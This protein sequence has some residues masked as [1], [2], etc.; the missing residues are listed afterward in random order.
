MSN[1]IGTSWSE[2]PPHHHVWLCH[3]NR[4]GSCGVSDSISAWLRSAN[5]RH[6]FPPAIIQHATRRY[7]RF[8]RATAISR[9]CW[10]NE[11]WTSPTKQCGAGC[12]SSALPLRDGC[13]GVARGRGGERVRDDFDRS[14]QC[15]EPPL[16][17][18]SMRPLARM[19]EASARKSGGLAPSPPKTSPLPWQRA[20]SIFLRDASRRADVRFAMDSPLEGTGFELLV[21]IAMARAPST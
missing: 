2:R 9:N 21:P 16:A 7:L 11:S 12:R 19:A 8:T 13:A 5:R 20:L 14:L 4:V 10:P 6:R 15:L 18:A 3:G 1:L 17:I